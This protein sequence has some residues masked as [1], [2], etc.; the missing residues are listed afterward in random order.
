MD[1]SDTQYAENATAI[2]PALPIWHV[3]IG[4]V[5]QEKDLS[6]QSRPNYK[7]YWPIRMFQLEHAKTTQALFSR[8]SILSLPEEILTDYIWV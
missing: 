3:S 7:E 5:M 4:L 2:P 1:S 8:M 6:E